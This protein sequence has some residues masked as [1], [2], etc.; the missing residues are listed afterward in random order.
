MPNVLGA[1]ASMDCASMRNVYWGTSAGGT[2]YFDRYFRGL[3]YALSWP[4]VSASTGVVSTQISRFMLTVLP[5]LFPLL[6]SSG[7]AA[8][9]CMSS[10]RGFCK[11]KRSNAA[12]SAPL[13]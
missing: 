8:Q 13:S 2:Y 12:Y 7:L 4:L 9:R 11:S 6:R 10:S 3:G 1:F 5:R